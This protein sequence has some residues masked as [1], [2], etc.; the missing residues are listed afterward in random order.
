MKHL[1][2]LI[3]LT[4]ILIVSPSFGQ[5]TTLYDFQ[6][7]QDGEHPM[8]DLFYDG[9]Y[10]YGMTYYGGSLTNDKGTIFKILPDGTNYTQI[11]A[12]DYVNGSYPEG[13]LI[14][15]G[16]FLYGVTSRGGNSDN[17]TIFKILPDGSGYTDFFNFTGGGGTGNEPI[18]DLL[19]DGTFLYGTTSMGG[20]A[21]GGT[22]F[23][24]MPDGTGY[25]K[26]YD[27]DAPNDG[28]TPRSALISDGIYLYGMTKGGGIFGS[29][30][31]FKILP[32]G[33]GYQKLF[34]FDGMTNGYYPQGSLVSDGTFLY[35]MTTSTGINNHSGTIFKILTDGT[36]YQNIFDFDAPS[37][38]GNLTGNYP[39]GS[40]MYDGT[41][42]YG[43][44][45]DG[46][47]INDDGTV[48][49]ILPDGT[50]FTKLWDF[51]GG[52]TE[53]G[54]PHGSLISDGTFLYGM[55]YWDGLGNLGVVFKLDITASI[56]DVDLE[57]K[58]NISPNPTNGQII[59]IVSSNSEQDIT[60]TN[61]IGKIIF[62]EEFNISAGSPIKIDLSD[63]PAGIYYLI[64]NDLIEKVIK[65]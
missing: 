45:A 20:A 24:I 49:K 26:L 38:V 60:I 29:G 39:M 40:L 51:S 64:C 11:H 58:I 48:F 61:S 30:T 13:S 41:F 3:G 35:G 10:L 23:R 57:S 59:L 28:W 14:S 56:D 21:N 53:G 63:Q 62:E 33:T 42:L 25:L 54:D 31:I 50:G 47:D 22:I 16:T 6:G 46:G 32:D 8:G 27:F 17:G 2:T 9:S 37:Q 19:Y 44:T 65:H 12:F 4:C 7:F 15:D 5:Y 34:D 36:G 1:L 43:M 55:T 52:F 18:G